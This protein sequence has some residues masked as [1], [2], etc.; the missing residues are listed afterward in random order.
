MPLVMMTLWTAVAKSVPVVGGGGKSW[1]TTAFISYFLSVFIVRQIISSW[2]S[3]EI[4]W[5]VRS[6]TLAMR[7]LR[8]MHPIIVYGSGNLAALPM[9]LLVT[10]PVVIVLFITG[11][12]AKLPSSVALWALW[13][14]SMF[15]GWLVTFFI[16]IAI[17]SLSLF[18]DSSIKVM[19]VWL[20]GFF[21]FSGYSV[22]ARSIAPT[23]LS[24]VAKCM[25]FRYQ[26]GLP[27]ELM[28]GAHDLSSALPLLAAQWTWV[29]ATGVLAVALWTIGVRRFQAFGG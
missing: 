6:G 16:N 5:E 25:P 19:D 10:F 7:L 11:A 18:M 24:T 2:A 15:G 23:W 26:I 14:L 13:L 9:R 20:A 17:G 28:T 8:P 22:P 12:F 1:G 4:N 27:V 3:W 21:V 29:V